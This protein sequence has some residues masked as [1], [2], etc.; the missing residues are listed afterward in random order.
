MVKELQQE[1]QKELDDFKKK[2]VVD[3]LTF[4]VNTMEKRKV[5][6]LDRF[7]NIREDDVKKIGL[8]HNKTRI[9]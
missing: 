4:N 1:K 8:R 3:S 5:A 6:Q 2:V 9:G 7:K